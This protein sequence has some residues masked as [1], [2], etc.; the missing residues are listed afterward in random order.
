VTSL[1]LEDDPAVSSEGV[2]R[3]C[4]A[5][6]ESRDQQFLKSLRCSIESSPFGK[7]D[8]ARPLLSKSIGGCSFGGGD[9]WP[10]EEMAIR[11]LTSRP[12]G[13]SREIL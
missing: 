10:L 12:L 7:V 1:G 13:V 3:D 2:I 5:A 11:L 4:Q 8:T 6:A 9:V